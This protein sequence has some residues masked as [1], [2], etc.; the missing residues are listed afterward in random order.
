MASGL[1]AGWALLFVRMISDLTASAVLAGTSNPVVGFRILEIYDGSSFATLAALSSVLTLI[2]AVVIATLL[3]L[4]RRR[5][6]APTRA[7][8][9]AVVAS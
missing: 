7:P 5:E 4:S 9:R 8:T 3:M 6:R 2:T 1:A